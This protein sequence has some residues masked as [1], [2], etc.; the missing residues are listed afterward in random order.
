M[1]EKSNIDMI[2]GKSL[3][4]VEET[5]LHLFNSGEIF[6]KVWEI[7]IS[8]EEIPKFDKIQS[9]LKLQ[10][11][12]TSNVSKMLSKSLGIQEKTINILGIERGNL[13][14]V[15]YDVNC[16]CNSCGS[17]DEK[18][19]NEKFTNAYPNSKFIIKK[20]PLFEVI[21]LLKII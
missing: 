16:E 3:S 9:S 17:L 20:H 14:K 1:F 21:N 13:T 6:R 18:I 19:F 2:I 5:S 10:K 11:E 8:E 12:V 7:S 4:A 15:I